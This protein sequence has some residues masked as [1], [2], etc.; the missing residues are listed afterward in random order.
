MIRYLKADLHRISRR[1]P[2]YIA[3]VLL[4]AVCII[5]ALFFAEGRTIYEIINVMTKIIPYVCCIFGLIEYIYVYSDDVKA[6][7]MQIAIGTGI[8]RGKV[9]LTKWLELL[10]LCVLDF[11][12]LFVV[13]CVCCTV[14]GASLSGEP[15]ADI[16]ILILFGLIKIMGCV[17]FTMIFHFR[18]QNASTGML[19][20]LA[21]AFGIVNMF[22]STL[23]TIGFL[24]NLPLSSML[25][26][27]LLDVARARAIIGSFSF[28]HILGIV[29]YLVAAYFITLKLFEKRE[30]EF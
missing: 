27:S 30:L 10:I 20:Y 12:V 19:V 29:I 1:I 17:G 15:A 21:S 18:T 6:K 13:F 14:R 4:Y 26:D 9:I 7:T 22:F 16:I 24:K 5:A 28:P 2:R 11:I 23:V 25:F 3:L 8:H